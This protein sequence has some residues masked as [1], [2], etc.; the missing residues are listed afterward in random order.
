MSVSCNC[1]FWSIVKISNGI[2]LVT[3]REINLERLQ[4]GHEIRSTYLP[5]ACT[6]E[7]P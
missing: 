4:V 6:A 3:Y 5:K 2:L 1:R 7:S